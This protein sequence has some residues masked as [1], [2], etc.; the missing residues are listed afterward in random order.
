MKSI[1]TPWHKNPFNFDSNSKKKSFSTATQ[2]PKA[3]P[4]NHTEMKIFSITHT[5]KSLS[6]FTAI[7]SSLISIL[8]IKLRWTIHTKCK[9]VCMLTPQT[10]DFRPEFQN[11]VHLWLPTQPYHFRPYTEIKSNLVPY[12]EIKSIWTTHTKTKLIEIL[13]LK[14]SDTRP[15]YK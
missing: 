12:T 7:K 2:K 1:S 13:K 3:M 10:S 5:T 8:K 6:S 4:I 9:S 15:A 11:Q 14:T